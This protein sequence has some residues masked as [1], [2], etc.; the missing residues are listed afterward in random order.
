MPRT[1]VPLAKQRAKAREENASSPDH[2]VVVTSPRPRRL[3]NARDLQLTT[4]IRHA[5]GAMRHMLTLA[6][7]IS[8]RDRSYGHAL[9]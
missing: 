8:I 5:K 9:G 2:G 6:Q 3:N 1:A 7:S 4:A